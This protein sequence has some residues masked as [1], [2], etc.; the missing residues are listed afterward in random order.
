MKMQTH[1]NSKM[2]SAHKKNEQHLQQNK[3]YRNLKKNYTY[4]DK[5]LYWA[6]DVNQLQTLSSFLSLFRQ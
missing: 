5:N 6:E 4:V 2:S 1:N 3:L